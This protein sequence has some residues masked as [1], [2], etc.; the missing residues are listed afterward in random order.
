MCV[1]GQ[2][3]APAALSLGENQYPLDRRLGEPQNLPGRGGEE[4]Y[5]LITGKHTLVV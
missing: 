4:K 3:K 5:I 2:F 1:S